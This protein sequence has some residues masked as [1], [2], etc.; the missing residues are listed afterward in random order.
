MKF[1]QKTKC[2]LCKSDNLKK[3]LELTPTPWADD[4][5][6]KENLSNQESIPLDLYQCQQCFHVQLKDIIDAEE[7]YLNYTYETESTL[8]LGDHFK[9][10]AK[11]IMDIYDNKNGLVIDIGSNDGILLKYFKDYGLD[12]LGIDPMPDIANKASKLGI[13]TLPIFFNSKNAEDVLKKYGKANIISSNNLVADT[14]DLDDFVDG[15]KKLLDKDGIFFFETF[16]FFLQVK[17][18]V[19]D[20]TYHEHYSYF[21]VQPLKKYFENKGFEIINV[22]PNLTKGGSMRCVLKLKDGKYPVKESVKN[23]I[24]EEI[25]AGFYNENFIKEYSD[26][27]NFSKKTF[28]K[29]ISKIVNNGTKISGYGASATSTTLIYH[30]EMGEMLDFLYDDFKVKHNLYSPG[31]HIKVL[32]SEDIY[33][34]K[35]EY[36][37]IL[38]WRY[39]GKIIEKN[40]KFLIDG[41]KF[42]LP[43]PKFKIIDK[44]YLEKKN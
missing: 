17:N 2:R 21:L 25:K 3:I 18:F 9:E 19:W 33:K 12:V 39:H 26:K 40:K 30:Y 24:D 28:K 6:R 10:T 8:G 36:I 20:F 16:Y 23:H 15:V 37:I 11:S 7:I 22:E 41:G 27:I 32:P 34:N 13:N 14:D 29:E 31:Y 1:Y 4:Y 42:I 35:P 43:L 5:R 38:A 44:N